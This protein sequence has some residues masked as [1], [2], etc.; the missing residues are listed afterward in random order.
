M[1]QHGYHDYDKIDK[2][3]RTLA[4]EQQV[5][6]QL[7]DGTYEVDV[8]EMRGV[9]KSTYELVLRHG[10][11]IHV[12][13]VNGEVF[14]LMQWATGFKRPSGGQAIVTIKSNVVV[15]VSRHEWEG[16]TA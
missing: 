15:S 6:G 10:Q 9:G 16:E 7:S 14:R 1:K 3:V 5:L 4:G 2:E 11:H 13:N 12:S 8:V